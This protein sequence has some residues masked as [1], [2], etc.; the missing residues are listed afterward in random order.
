MTSFVLVHTAETISAVHYVM[1]LFGYPGP[2]MEEKVDCRASMALEI[3]PEDVQWMKVGGA[4]GNGPI[5]I[6][7]FVESK[8]SDQIGRIKIIG[9]LEGFQGCGCCLAFLLITPFIAGD[10]LNVLSC[11]SAQDSLFKYRKCP[12]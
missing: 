12:G 6:L 3:E 9:W 10:Q 8:P 11:S 4:R 1:S 2:K 5:V 7:L